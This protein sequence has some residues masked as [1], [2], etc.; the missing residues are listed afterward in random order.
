MS[1]IGLI[2]AVQHFSLGDGPGIR[3]TVFFKGC[4]LHCLWCHNPETWKRNPELMYYEKKCIGCGSC[5][6][7]CP[8]E[9]H[10]VNETGHIFH[11]ER[12]TACGECLKRCPTRALEMSG[13]FMST[14]EV[15][16]Q[17]KEDAD[18]YEASGGGVTF[19]GGEPLLQDE[20]CV[21][22][23]RLCSESGIDVLI[24]TCADVPF[25]VFEQLLK[26]VKSYYIDL[27]AVS[28]EA[29]KQY[30]GGSLLRIK[31]NIAQ[32]IALHADVT[33]RIPVIPGYNDTD[34][35]CQTAVKLLRE[36]GVTKL[37]LLPFHRM[38]ESKYRALQKHY[39][40]AEIKPPA[41]QDI[42]HFKAIFSSA[43]FQIIKE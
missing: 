16:A 12:C 43:G 35:F 18:Y 23:A 19:S 39:A 2:S 26:Y 29:Y 8:N 28:E 5:A 17:L 3:S 1:K 42:E 33:V 9:A 10:S 21:E 24:E 15:F 20:F 4:A 6:K 22:L 38:G 14:E 36:L 25:H 31:E 37:E 27:K 11:R 13:T 41:K 34:D 40:Y 32:L 30:T 7:V